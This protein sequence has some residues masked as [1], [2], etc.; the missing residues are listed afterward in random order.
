MCGYFK[1]YMLY[2]H[3]YMYICMHIYTHMCTY[4]YIIP[5]MCRLFPLLIV[6][7]KPLCGLLMGSDIFMHRP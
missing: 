6:F 3:A 1:C 4:T 2:V 5:F 7:V